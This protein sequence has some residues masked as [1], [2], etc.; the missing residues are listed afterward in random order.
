MGRNLVILA[1]LIVA[2]G[3]GSDRTAPAKTLADYAGRYKTEGEMLSGK[4]LPYL[5]A[6]VDANGRG[7]VDG[8]IPGFCGIGACGSDFQLNIAGTDESDRLRVEVK[9]NTM[10]VTYNGYGQQVPQL[11]LKKVL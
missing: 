6:I 8:R 11:I 2:T 9:G 3:C 7:E 4:G 10:L 1:A 5:E